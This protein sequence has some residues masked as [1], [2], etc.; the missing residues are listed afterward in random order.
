MQE[1]DKDIEQFEESCQLE[2][3][4]RACGHAAVEKVAAKQTHL[5]FA[6]PNW[7]FVKNDVA[8]NMLDKSERQGSLL[9]LKLCSCKNYRR[10]GNAIWRRFGGTCRIRLGQ[11]LKRTKSTYC[12]TD[13]VCR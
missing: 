10:D 5:N 6:P 7:P 13:K 3:L 11:T 2:M 1:D 8:G 9:N 4:A 12:I